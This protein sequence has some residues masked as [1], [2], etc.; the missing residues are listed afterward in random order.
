MK[1][2]Y[3][4]FLTLDQVRERIPYSRT[5]IWRLE[6]ARAFPRRVQIGPNR[7]AWLEAEIENW[8][9]DRVNERMDNV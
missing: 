6:K 5:Q 3:S 9:Q 4:K 1:P 2:S 8:L 7:V